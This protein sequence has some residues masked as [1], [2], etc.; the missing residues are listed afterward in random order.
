M[1][2]RHRFEVRVNGT[3][4]CVAG[5]PEPGVLQATLE[6]DDWAEGYLPVGTPI[7]PDETKCGLTVGGMTQDDQMLEWN[8]VRLQPGDEVTVRVL[9][10]GEAEEPKLY[11]YDIEEWQPW[12]KRKDQDTSDDA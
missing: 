11:R 8:R 1:P 9:P 2:D 4:L 7:E 10:S 5:M 3:L 12:A 6:A